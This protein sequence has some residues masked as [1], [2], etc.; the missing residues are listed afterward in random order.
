MDDDGDENKAASAMRNMISIYSDSLQ[1]R[2]KAS[3]KSKGKGKT[4]LGSDKVLIRKLLKQVDDNKQALKDQEKTLNRI[5]T[6]VKRE[7]LP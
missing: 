1:N 3:E 2:V 7:G 5:L 6:L 4:K